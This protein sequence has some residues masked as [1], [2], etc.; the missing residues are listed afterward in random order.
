MFSQYPRVSICFVRSQGQIYE[1]KE[2]EKYLK[3]KEDEDEI[4][5]PVTKKPL[6][7]KILIPSVHVRNNIEHLVESGIVEGEMADT[8]KERMEEKRDGELTV[9]RWREG[10][11][12]G[13][14]G[15]M[16][17]LGVCYEYGDY[18]IE[19]D[20]GE[21]YRWYKKSADAGNV[22]G[23]AAV[24]DSLLNGCGVEE[25]RTEGLI[26]L[27]SAAKD[28][29]DWACYIVGKLYFKGLFGSK[30]NYAK[31]KFWLQKAVAEGE[32][33][34]EHCHLN[35]TQIKNAQT[36]TAECNAFLDA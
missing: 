22:M 6:E 35:E 16:Y 26:M 11:E 32:G 14:T 15:A 28:G 2:I 21:A 30:V 3:K 5:S 18:D 10:A 12:K 1:R 24:G 13:D 23:M 4:L 19:K 36:W 27:V 29:S 17:D 9:K 20:A 25:D 7:T 34:C 31:A 8:W 33:S